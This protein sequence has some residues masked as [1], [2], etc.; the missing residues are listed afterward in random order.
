MRKFVVEKLDGKT[1][2][3]NEVTATANVNLCEELTGLEMKEYRK[4]TG[5][6]SWLANSTR[7]DLCYTSLAMSKNNKGAT[8][9]NL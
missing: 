8:I 4:I 6:I 2:N 7:P 5:K 1:A 3:V 9:G